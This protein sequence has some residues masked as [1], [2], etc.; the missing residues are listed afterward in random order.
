M[1]RVREPP[2]CGHGGASRRQ[3]GKEGSALVLTV[4]DSVGRARGRR[5]TLVDIARHAGVSKSTVSLVLQSSPL[6]REET[7]ERVH[8]AIDALGYVYNRSAANL[9]RAQSNVVG[10]VINDLGNPFF[11]ELAVGIER[12]FQTA[13][14]V[15]LIANSA[16]SPIRQAEVLR[17]I[18]EQGP[19]GFIICPA[20]GTQPAAIDDLIRGGLPVVLAMRR[21]AGVRAT[22][23]APDNRDGARKAVEHLLRLGHRRIAYFGG[24]ADTV[25]DGER[26]GG[27]RDA[28]AAAGLAID[29]ALVISG[30]PTR[31]SGM[32]GID[33]L[34]AV[35]DE[36]T[37]G[38]C[39]NDLVALGVMAGLRRQGR[40]AGRDFAVIGFDDIAEA[41][42]ASPA[43]TT[44]A[45]DTKALGER[46]AQSVLGMIQGHRSMESHVGAV[47]LVVRESC[48]ARLKEAV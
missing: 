15:P 10:M 31:E 2:R 12:V 19:A 4:V 23:V 25:V 37:A 11:A 42:H 22:C 32:Q 3:S 48:G 9:R 17:S 29:E 1:G 13:G 8:R 30:A 47:D 5:V 44:V 34:R 35:A 43:L 20:R 39:F 16:E 28:L 40:E 45:V 18:R 6:V 27:Y 24:F 41:R 7:R 26:Q 21:V 14:F 46:A 38:L 33:R 36:A